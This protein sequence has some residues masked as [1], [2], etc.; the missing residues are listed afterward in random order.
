MSHKGLSG[1]HDEGESDQEDVAFHST[2]GF[3][4]AEAVTEVEDLINSGIKRSDALQKTADR[5]GY[6]PH[7]IAAKMQAENR[8][9]VTRTYEEERKQAQ[10]DRASKLWGIC[11]QIV[12]SIDEATIKRA[13]LADRARVY[14]VLSERAMALTAK[15][16]ETPLTH[17]MAAEML[18]RLIN[19]VVPPAEDIEAYVEDLPQLSLPS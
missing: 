11:D 9:D 1:P 3:S 5:Y 7:S 15:H 16:D 12:D 14:H 10:I 13:S 19:K 2:P 4:M 6:S 18:A 17:E 8:G